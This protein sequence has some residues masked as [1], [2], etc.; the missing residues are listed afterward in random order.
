[1]AGPTEDYAC[2]LLHDKSDLKGV[3]ELKKAAWVLRKGVKRRT[4]E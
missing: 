2:L 4:E 1:M 3:M